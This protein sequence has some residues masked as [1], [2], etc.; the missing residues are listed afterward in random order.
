MQVSVPFGKMAVS[1]WKSENVE[2][3][4]GQNPLARTKSEPR[5]LRKKGKGF[6]RRVSPAVFKVQRYSFPSDPAK[7]FPARFSAVTSSLTL[8]S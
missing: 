5:C 4:Y 7:A 3:A 1:D 2:A 8:P 6:C